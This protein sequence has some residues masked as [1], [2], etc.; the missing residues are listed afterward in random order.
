[1]TSFNN[2]IH[3]D[4]LFIPLYIGMIGIIGYAWFTESTKV[5]ANINTDVATSPINSLTSW[6]Y[7]W[8]ADRVTNASLID[9]QNDQR[10]L[11]RFQNQTEYNDKLSEN[12]RDIQQTSSSLL[13]KLEEIKQIRASVPTDSSVIIKNYVERANLLDNTAIITDWVEKANKLHEAGSSITG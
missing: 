10:Q 7:N 4:Y 5:F 8:S 12:L 13:E 9:Q 6:P 2:L 3:N 11:L 1:M